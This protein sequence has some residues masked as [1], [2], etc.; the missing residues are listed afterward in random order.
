M[1]RDPAARPPRALQAE[2]DRRRAEAN[3]TLDRVLSEVRD[4]VA[5][6]EFA[7]VGSLNDAVAAATSGL[8][9]INRI[10]TWPWRPETLRGFLSAVVL[11]IVIWLITALLGRIVST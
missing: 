1:L 10:S 9:T 8:N 5:A 4:R 3:Q 7:Q 6:G 2:K 11:P